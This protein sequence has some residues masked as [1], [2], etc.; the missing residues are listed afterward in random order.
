MTLVHVWKAQP[1]QGFLTFPWV[2]WVWNEFPTVVSSA[3]GITDSQIFERELMWFRNHYFP[4]ITD[5]HDI[6]DSTIFNWYN[7]PFLKVFQHTVS[8]IFT[9]KTNSIDKEGFTLIGSIP[10][11][12]EPLIPKPH[13]FPLKN[14]GISD[15]LESPDS[16]CRWDDC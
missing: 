5:S 12:G 8:N 6:T 2:A 4:G 14:L 10:K 13:E 16:L 11:F 15:S 7:K 3:E 9:L 1:S